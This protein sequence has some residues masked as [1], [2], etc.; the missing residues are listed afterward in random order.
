MRVPLADVGRRGRL[1][2]T[3]GLQGGRTVL[4]DSYCEVPF[5]ITRLL[6][7]NAGVPQMILM[8]CTA[9]LFGGD[10]VECSIRVERGAGV[11]I[12]QQS[13]TKVHPSQERRA[14][15][16]NRIY[17]ESE[18]TLEMFLEPII[19]FADSRLEQ[20]THIEVEPGGQLAYWEGFMTGRVGRGESWCFAEL[21]SETSLSSNGTLAYLD[22]FRL[23]RADSRWAMNNATYLGT[24]L[25]WSPRARDFAEAFHESLPQA[26]VD[27]VTEQLVA[28]RVVSNNG[29]EFHRSRDAFCTLSLRERVARSAG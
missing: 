22:R 8:Q 2:L 16:R 21:T 20:A 28:V 4:K 24:G 1:S 25:Y 17:V 23:A 12:T 7:S 11:R 9:G 18:A 27:A 6:N 14:V 10:E 13:A 26:G 5:K 29:P 15:Q 19:P 3:F